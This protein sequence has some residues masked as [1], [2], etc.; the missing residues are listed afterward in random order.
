MK[1]FS[2]KPNLNL[3]LQVRQAALAGL[4]N[5]FC[6][7]RMIDPVHWLPLCGSEE[8]FDFLSSFSGASVKQSTPDGYA[9]ALHT[10]IVSQESFAVPSL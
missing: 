4:T 1:L 9:S 5:G 10:L 7:E 3:Q 8:V 2:M 6:W